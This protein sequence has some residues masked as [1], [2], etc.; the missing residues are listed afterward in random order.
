MAPPPTARSLTRW[1]PLDTLSVGGWTILVIAALSSVA[2]AAWPVATRDGLQMW[3][4]AKNHQVLY[5]PMFAERNLRAAEDPDQEAVVSTLLDGS[6]MLRRLLAGFWG[7]T[8]LPDMVEVETNMMS[9]F[10]SGPLESMGFV[11][12]TDRLRA[13]GLDERINP[14]SFTPWTTRG[15]IFGIPHDVHPTALAYR[16]DLFAEAGIDVDAIE[17]WD[18]FERLTQPLLA[19]DDGDGEPDHYPLAIWYSDIGT[20]ETLLFQADGGYFRPDG[21]PALDRAANASVVARV[22]GWCFGEDRI[23]IDAPKFTFSGNQLKLQGRVACEIMPDW[24]IG[25]WKREL[26]GLG[27]KFKLMPLPAWEPGG[28]R[29]SVMGGT[30]LGFPK[31]TLRSRGDGSGEP[32]FEAAWSFAMDLYFDRDYA[33]RLYESTSII[34]PLTDL[35]SESFYHEPDPFFGGQRVGT[36]LLGLAPDVPARVPSPFIEAA[37]LRMTEVLG[38]VYRHA[39]AT[40]AH[41]AATLE[42]LAMELLAEAQARLAEEMSRN[43]FLQAGAA[44]PAA[45]A[46][47]AVP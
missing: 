28:R 4:F 36:L 41:D 9:R 30:M 31:R 34:S 46:G 6:A 19:D 2:I 23:A 1:R 35:W 17:T 5:E 20:I 37:R 11:D 16:A 32:S 22:V 15:R 33:Q 25:V 44:G 10:T 18:D 29:I 3:I 47:G 24:L 27:G 40:G 13:E 38:A 39:E 45:A 26:P 8:P 14:P 12:L 21:T 7:D 43:V 42:P